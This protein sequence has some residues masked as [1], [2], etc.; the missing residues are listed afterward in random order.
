[1]AKIIKVR[2]LDGKK[3][4]DKENST[5][6]KGNIVVLKPEESEIAQ[7]LKITEKGSYSIKN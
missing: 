7:R 4:V 3:V 6:L 2:E 5:G 1:M